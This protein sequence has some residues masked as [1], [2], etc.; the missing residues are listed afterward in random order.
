LRVLLYDVLLGLVYIA[1]DT[2]LA[3]WYFS[4]GH[5]Y[6]AALTLGAMALPGTL[7]LLGYTF[8]YLSGHLEGTKLQQFK[9]F[10]FWAFFFGP[11]LF[12]LSLVVWH[13][14][15][16]CRGEEKFNQF[17][18]LARSRVLSSL[19]V[20][21]KSAL[22]LCLQVT[23]LMIT[24]LKHDSLP[25]HTY[26]LASIGLSTLIIAKSCAD[27]HY[28]EISG[29]NVRVR[30]P[31]CQLIVRMSF[32][33]LHILFRGAVLGLLASYLHY[34][35]VAF[36][37]VM[38][39]ANYI[40]SNVIIKTDGSKHFWTAFAAVLLPNCFISRDTVEKIEKQETRR[41]FKM[42]YKVNSLL[43]FFLIGVG[44]LVA[45]NCLIFLTDF[46]SF[47]C[48]NLPI[49]S[50]DPSQ[51]CPASSP[52]KDLKFPTSV[53]PHSGFLYFGTAG[54]FVLCL[55]HVCLVFIEEKILSKDYEPVPR[56]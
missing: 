12:P 34:L 43:F 29:K 27:H 23:I 40:A 1:C 48:S 18:T 2:Y 53:P 41:K 11:F 10:S 50:Y 35:S 42:F 44:A 22:Q 13:L 20:L 6:W 46:I 51:N 33:I 15:M 9:E 16:V 32:N 38:I 4:H 52:I 24:W 14:V 37:G 54:V 49:L 36:I 17:Q 25:Y 7:E 31:Y 45:A 47:N 19:S 39:L 3:Y 55:L 21:T 56:M 8:S 28:F 30:S 5:N 26:Q